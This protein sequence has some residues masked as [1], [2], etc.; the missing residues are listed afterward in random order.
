MMHRS[1]GEKAR[2]S[3]KILQGGE[4]KGS[5]GENRGEA[6]GGQDNE[7]SG[8]EKRAKYNSNMF[9]MLSS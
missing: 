6:N 1:S 5:I 9:R 7:A 2:G 8:R 3:L 4:R